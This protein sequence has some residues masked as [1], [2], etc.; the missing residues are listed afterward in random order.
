M[1]IMGDLVK[2]PFGTDAAHELCRVPGLFEPGKLYKRVQI[3]ETLRSEFVKRGGVD[4]T[5][6]DQ[7]AKVLKKWLLG[8]SSTFRKERRGLYRFVGFNGQSD[9]E[10][11]LDDRHIE[12]NDS[13]NDEGLNP[14]REIGEGPC[15]VYAWCLPQYQEMSGDRWPIKIGR[16]GPDGLRRRLRDFQEN[17]PEWPRYLLRLGCADDREARER[18]FLL[19]AW[20]KSRGQKLDHLPGEEWFLTNPREI[21]KAIQNIIHADD[22]NDDRGAPAI[23]DEIAAAFKDVTV[24]DWARLPAD[25]TDRLDDY[26]YGDES[27]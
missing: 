24:E 15:E 7:V 27:T 11:E 18:E 16:A 22:P 6:K 1:D 12:G 9:Q 10:L 13:A 17:L 14:G 20:F 2:E 23:E 8:R 3:S 19:H 5:T 21:E 25:L 26:L 4:T